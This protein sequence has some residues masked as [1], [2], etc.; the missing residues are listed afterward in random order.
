MKLGNHDPWM[1]T[2]PFGRWLGQMGVRR[3]SEALL[4]R[5]HSC[6]TQNVF[7]PNLHAVTLVAFLNVKSP[8]MVLE[9]ISAIQETESLSQGRPS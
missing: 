9:I 3:T 7:W 5:D 6:G 2:N 1:A 8:P 4:T